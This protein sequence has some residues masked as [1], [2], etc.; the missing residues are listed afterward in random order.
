MSDQVRICFVG[1]FIGQDEAET[2]REEFYKYFG[3]DIKSGNLA[4]LED[5]ISKINLKFVVRIM[6]QNAQYELD[7]DP[8]D[9]NFTEALEPGD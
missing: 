5:T 6:A 9:E 7:F 3:E 2:Y 4:I 1:S 8:D